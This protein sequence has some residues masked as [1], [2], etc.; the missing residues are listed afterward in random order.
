[1]VGPVLRELAPGAHII[2]L[3]PMMMMMMRGVPVPFVWDVT[4][5]ELLMTGV[6]RRRS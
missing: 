4:W 6:A 2:D 1:M 5:H 3:Q